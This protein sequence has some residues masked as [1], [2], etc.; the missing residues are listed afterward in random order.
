MRIAM[1]V[2]GAGTMYCGACARD[3]DL[4]RALISE[5]HDVAVFPI[6]TPLRLEGEIGVDPQPLRIGGI[7][8]FLRTKFPPAALFPARFRRWLDSPG[9][10]NWAS[11][12]AVRTQAAD[13]GQLTVSFLRGSAGPHARAIQLL[14]DDVAK[15]Q[16]QVVVL[17]NSLLAGL[18]EALANA[19]HAPV[20]CQVQGED[21]FLDELPEGWRAKAENLLREKT[22]EA[23]QFIAPCAAHAQDMARR[24]AQPIERFAIVPPSFRPVAGGYPTRMSAAIRIG[25]LS[26]IRRAKGLDLLVE[27]MSQLADL[28][29]EFTVGGKVL[30]PAFYAEVIAQAAS[31]NVKIEFGG[32]IAP[33]DK[34]AFVAHCDFVVLP[35]RL[36]ESRGIAALEALAL[37]TPVIAPS[38]G[39][40]PELAKATGGVAIYR[41]K[42][43]LASTIRACVADHAEWRCRGLEA[44]LRVTERYSSSQAAAAAVACFERILN[45]PVQ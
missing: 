28:S 13:L 1:V 38:T 40:F 17:A 35:S 16:P 20:F 31:A 36:R 24:L 30:E 10:L 8:A 3:G 21:G 25:H 41:S 32:E 23:A 7:N 29:L 15:F 6:Y 2:A 27:A 14:A 22:K 4:A 26:S 18:I 39:I 37:G 34:A 33:H 43:E 12:F 5:G 11:Q 42:N 9:V 19:T 45:A 44:A